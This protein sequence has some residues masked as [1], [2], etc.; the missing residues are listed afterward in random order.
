MG[1]RCMPSPTRTRPTVS[2]TPWSGSSPLGGPAQGPRGG[3]GS[4]TPRADEPGTYAIRILAA[5]VSDRVDS[6]E[7]APVTGIVTTLP[8]GAFDVIDT[9]ILIVV[10]APTASSSGCPMKDHSK[11]G[12]G[13]PWSKN[14]RLT[15]CRR[16]PPLRTRIVSVALPSF[17]IVIANV[18]ECPLATFLGI[19]W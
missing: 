11:A 2:P 10:D 4:G 9:T 15:P 3:S 8:V 6:F 16:N 7:D 14:F 12:I 19:V 13:T 1:S 5:T 18:T 17:W